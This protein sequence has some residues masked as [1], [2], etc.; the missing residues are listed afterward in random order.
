[1][2]NL[3]KEFKGQNGNLILNETSLVIKRGLKGFLLGGGML[4]GEKTIPYESIVAVQLKPSGF[5]VGYLQLTLKGGSEAKGGFLQSQ[6]DENTI[7]FTKNEVF[8]E[9]KKII[10]EKIN[11]SSKSSNNSLEDLQKLAEMR[12]KGILT[13]EEFTAKKKQILKI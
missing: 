12:D 8:L 9:A 11:A 4:R 6:K 2:T 5:L 1:M 10:E 13:E 7:R 3:P